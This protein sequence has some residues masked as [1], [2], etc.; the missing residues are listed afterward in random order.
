MQ[1]NVN[2]IIAGSVL[3]LST[4]FSGN[5]QAQSKPPVQDMHATIIKE[6]ICDLDLLMKIAL[7][8]RGYKTTGIKGSSADYDLEIYTNEKLGWVLMGTSKNEKIAP[9]GDICEVAYGTHAQ[10]YTKTSWF[11][12]NFARKENIVSQKSPP[13]PT[14][15]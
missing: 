7:K 2:K 11:L 15:N 8:H 10:P 6:P 4:L 3:A 13:K 14:I 9:L 1:N 12:E 5:A